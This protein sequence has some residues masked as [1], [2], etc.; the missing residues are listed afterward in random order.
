MRGYS[1]TPN[2]CSDPSLTS[3]RTQPSGLRETP[4][5]R[6]ERGVHAAEGHGWDGAFRTSLA[7]ARFC[8]LKAALLAAPSP[9]VSI[10]VHPWLINPAS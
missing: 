2:R 8:G 4:G 1:I 5:E 3:A 7:G 10:R 6:A 9:S